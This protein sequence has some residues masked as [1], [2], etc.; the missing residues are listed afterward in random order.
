MKIISLLAAFVLVLSLS[1]SCSSDSSK[2]SLE[3]FNSI[4][5]GMTYDEV[6]DI[7]GSEGELLSE[8]GSELGEQ[9]LT[10]TYTWKGEGS[11]ASNASIIFQGGKVLSKAQVGLE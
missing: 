11:D 7:I 2:I 9:Y 8:A 5:T 4:N 3:E 10:Q 1:V 6:C